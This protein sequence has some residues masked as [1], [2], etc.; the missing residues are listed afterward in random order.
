[1]QRMVRLASLKCCN[2]SIIAGAS[3]DTETAFRRSKSVMN[4]FQFRLSPDAHLHYNPPFLLTVA[5]CGKE[6]F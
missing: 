6:S 5:L 3:L 2:L 4:I 1:M